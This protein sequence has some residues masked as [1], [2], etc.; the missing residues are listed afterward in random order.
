MWCPL[1]AT[2]V[3]AFSQIRWGSGKIIPQNY[4][5]YTWQAKVREGK[6]LKSYSYFAVSWN[7]S[8]RLP[9]T[10]G[11]LPHCG[12]SHPD[13]LRPPPL[14]CIQLQQHPQSLPPPVFSCLDLSKALTQCRPQLAQPHTP[15]RNWVPYVCSYPSGW[16]QGSQP[17]S[18]QPRGTTI[19]PC[20]KKGEQVCH[21]AWRTVASLSL[22]YQF[23]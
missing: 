23:G 14:S 12:L 18:R 13:S 2:K 6:P 11:C 9:A 7:P 15:G 5:V 19:W 17:K 22:V 1:K 21:W 20:Q 4:Q 3:L 16:K 10:P 8:P